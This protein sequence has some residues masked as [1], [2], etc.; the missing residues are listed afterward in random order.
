MARKMK[1]TAPG[2]LPNDKP[3]TIHQ[4]A[5]NWPGVIFAGAGALILFLPVM[6]GCAI[7]IASQ[8]GARKPGEAVAQFIV[9]ML[10]V[11]I[12]IMIAKFVLADLVG[13]FLQNRVELKQLE[14]EAMR[15]DQLAAQTA[16]VGRANTE[17]TRFANLV[18]LVM[19]HAYDRMDELGNVSGGKPWAWRNCKDL[20]LAN[21]TKAVGETMAR[22]VRPFLEAHRIIIADRVNTKRYGDLRTVNHLLWKLYDIPV[23]VNPTPPDDTGSWSIVEN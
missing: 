22:R 23:A 20:I 7:F 16:P 6:W 9:A 11:S 18:L 3:P 4:Y 14:I 8:L 13:M 5:T 17:D 12:V 15:Y 21:E 10:I 2:V 1:N 19:W